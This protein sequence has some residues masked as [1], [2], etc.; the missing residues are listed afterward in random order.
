MSNS[1]NKITISSTSSVAFAN[2]AGA[3]VFQRIAPYCDAPQ[4]DSTGKQVVQRFDLESAKRLVA[5]FAENIRKLAETQ[6]GSPSIPVFRG[7]PDHV[8]AADGMR[9]SEIYARVED[10]EARDDGLWAKIRKLPALANLKKLLGRLEISPRWACSQAN[11]GT[12]KPDE[13]ISLGLVE[14][15]NLPGADVIN[16]IQNKTMMDEE[17]MNKLAEMLGCESTAEAVLA[18]AEQMKAKLAEVESAANEAQEQAKT[19]KEKADENEEKLAAA[20]ARISVLEAEAK[21]RA[22]DL[23]N[24]QKNEAKKL[25]DEAHLAGKIEPAQRANL[26]AF[27]DK[28]FANAKAFVESLKPMT[29]ESPL[30][31]I[32]ELAKSDEDGKS[33]EALA[34]EYWQTQK[35]AGRKISLANAISEF[36]KTRKGAEAL[37]AKK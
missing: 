2:E 21:K 8:N 35:E 13:L 11:D 20:N 9:D 7:H 12:F 30:S 16:S 4:Y 33:F 18:A 10:L 3:V 1:E 28:D 34:N 6:I 32:N 19:E 29:K 23:A 5:A 15:G 36:S 27:F 17:T 22:E 31:K 37:A 26:E 14:K 24:A 25:L